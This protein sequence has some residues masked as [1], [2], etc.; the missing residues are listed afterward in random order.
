MPKNNTKKGELGKKSTCS[1]LDQVVA[2]ALLI[3]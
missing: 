3:F 1:Y 2:T